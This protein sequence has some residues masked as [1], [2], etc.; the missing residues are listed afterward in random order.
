VSGLGVVRVEQEALEAPDELIA[1]SEM[2]PRVRYSFMVKAHCVVGSFGR[3]LLSLGRSR[4]AGCDVIAKFLEH[5]R[6]LIVQ[7]ER[8]WVTEA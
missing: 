7:A 3:A 6:S 1:T 4:Q 8:K 5:S 2:A